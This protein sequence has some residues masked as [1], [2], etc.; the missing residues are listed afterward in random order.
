MWKLI[1]VNQTVRWAFKRLIQRWRS[2]RLRQINTEDVVT[3]EAPKQPVWIYDWTNRTKYVFE[4]AT[5]FRGIRTRL[6]F[7]QD[8]F[9]SP[10]QPKNPYTNQPLTYGQLHFALDDL[11]A[12]GKTDWVTETLRAVAYDLGVF[13]RRNNTQL[14]VAAL[15][16]LFANPSD[17]NYCDLLFDFIDF[18]HDEAEIMMERKDV[19]EWCIQNRHEHT[20]IQIWRG[21]CYTY[22]H[23]LITLGTEDFA[24]MKEQI[25]EKV[26]PLLRVSLIELIIVWRKSTA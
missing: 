17:D 14:R 1:Q 8:L 18:C 2:K 13:K 15:K 7:A 3:M 22:Y 9:P 23:A 10:Q 24:K 20:Q 21:Y 26:A 6:L 19:W 5:L 4:A 16:A 11:R 12:V 25:L